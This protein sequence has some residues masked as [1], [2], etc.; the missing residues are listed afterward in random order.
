MEHPSGGNDRK[1]NEDK[2]FREA[3]DIENASV[4]QGGEVRLAKDALAGF[5]PRTRVILCTTDIPSVETATERK[6]D[7][8]RC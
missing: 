5:P 6:S 2:G 7:V 1:A 3:G 4:P 8:H